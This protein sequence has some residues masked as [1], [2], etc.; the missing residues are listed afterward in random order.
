[1]VEYFSCPL[2]FIPASVHDWWARFQDL[3]KYPHT[4]KSY[5]ERGDRWH[6]FERYFTGKLDEYRQMMKRDG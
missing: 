2:K 3:E 5:D 1:M 4:A 6:S